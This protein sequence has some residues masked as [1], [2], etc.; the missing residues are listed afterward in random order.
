MD[1]FLNGTEDYPEAIICAN[2]YMAISICDALKKRGKRVPEDVCVSGFDGILEGQQNE[3]SLTTIT[4]RP[5]DFAEKIFD[6]LDELWAAK[7]S[8]PDTDLMNEL[9]LRR[10]CGCGKQQAFRGYTE[11]A[12]AIRDTDELLRE[13]GK[14]I[15]D[16]QNN[17]RN[18]GDSLCPFYNYYFSLWG[19]IT[20]IC[21]C[22]T[23]TSR[24]SN[25]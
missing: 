2:D 4:I 9:T 22:A 13:A 1:F 15:A 3:P 10:S 12:R 8:R 20:A 25:R 17:K 7:G 11:S 23:K 14:I 24:H 18:F 19:A 21:A 16:Y 5:E 6:A